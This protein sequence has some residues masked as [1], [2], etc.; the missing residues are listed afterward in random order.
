[1]GVSLFDLGEASLKVWDPFQKVSI[2][3]STE[4]FLCPRHTADNMERKGTQSVS[5]FLTETHWPPKPATHQDGSWD[6]GGTA[7]SEERRLWLGEAR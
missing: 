3:F 7:V 2:A 4:R 6:R 5:A 1:M